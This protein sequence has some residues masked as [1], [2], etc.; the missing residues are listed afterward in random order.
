MNSEWIVRDEM[1][2]YLNPDD[3]GFSGKEGI[4]DGETENN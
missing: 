3:M 1:D 2:E 4:D